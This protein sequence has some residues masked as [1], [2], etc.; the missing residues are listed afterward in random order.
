MTG[1]GELRHDPRAGARRGTRPEVQHEPPLCD[2]A[3]A[4]AFEFLGKRWSGVIL[5]TLTN[6]PLNFSELRRSVAGISD[7]ML[8]D[9][10]TELAKAGLVER[11]VQDGPPIAVTYSLTGCGAALTPALRELT[12]WA[13][14]NLPAAE[15]ARARET[16]RRTTTRSRRRSV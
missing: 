4:R 14:E 8:S 12:T 7:S 15:C 5:A 2:A 6:G 3:L 11:T 1:T 9:R 16:Q 13:S 10:L